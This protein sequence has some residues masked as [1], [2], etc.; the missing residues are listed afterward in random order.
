MAQCALK[1][2]LLMSS[3]VHLSFYR[4]EMLFSNS[5]T[6]G[7]TSCTFESIR[8]LDGDSGHK[9]LQPDKLLSKTAHK[10]ILYKVILRV[11]SSK[12]RITLLS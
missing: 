1:C 10:I 3:Y 4:S 7:P 5:A 6:I 12:P 2:P 8:D 9:M 11:K